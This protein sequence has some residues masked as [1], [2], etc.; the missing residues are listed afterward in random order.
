MLQA[1]L[2]RVPLPEVLIRWWLRH[3][4]AQ[5]NARGAWHRLRDDEEQARYEAVRRLVSRHAA[6]G[7]VLDVGCSQGIL[8]EGLVYRRYEG[9]DAFAG[10]IARASVRADHR[11][12]FVHA[13]G[14]RYRPDE[15]PDVIV[16]NEVVY[17]LPDPLASVDHYVGLLSPGG[18]LIVSVYARAWVLRRLLARIINRPDRLDLVETVRVSSGTRAW[19]VAV[20]RPRT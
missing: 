7:F 12:R 9:V 10:A 4:N 8:R 15:A 1:L 2:D 19:D 17:Y 5:E 3:D 16:L 18:V 11:T 20:L 14:A 13:D 6:D